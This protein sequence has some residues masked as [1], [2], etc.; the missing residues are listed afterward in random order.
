[1][2]EH[3]SH[4]HQPKQQKAWEM[5]IGGELENMPSV[6]Q[7]IEERTRELQ[8]DGEL[9]PTVEELVA[10]RMGSVEEEIARR[11]AMQGNLEQV[12]G[13]S[14]RFTYPFRTFLTDMISRAEAQ[15]KRNKGFRKVLTPEGVRFRSTVPVLNE[16]QEVEYIATFDYKRDTYGTPQLDTYSQTL[17]KGLTHPN[18]YTSRLRVKLNEQGQIGSVGVYYYNCKETLSKRISELP[19]SSE[20]TDMLHTAADTAYSGPFR[21]VGVEL[22]FGT[23]ASLPTIRFHAGNNY[24]SVGPRVV[25]ELQPEE[26]NFQLSH[27]PNTK[28]EIRYRNYFDERFEDMERYAISSG[29]YI[30]ALKTMLAFIPGAPKHEGKLDE[31][32]F[33]EMPIDEAK[34]FSLLDM[35]LQ[36]Q[37]PLSPDAPSGKL[38][39]IADTAKHTLRETNETVQYWGNVPAHV[40]DAIGFYRRGH[41]SSFDEE[42]LHNL[43][44]STR[45]R[46]LTIPLLGFGLVVLALCAGSFAQEVVEKSEEERSYEPPK[47]RIAPKSEEE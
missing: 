32:A 3:D 1:M 33:P 37:A 41:A 31:S 7:L 21:Y 39:K 42:R 6:E 28:F 15:A 40:A 46:F 44:E 5:H 9:L 27:I 24:K 14:E 36:Q 47:K 43:L 2:S 12:I 17:R 8:L 20:L 25:Y 38:S 10:Q 19:A 13:D 18:Q 22:D 35:F 34:V 23:N 45:D 30:A 4:N 11:S 16:N 26:N 29:D